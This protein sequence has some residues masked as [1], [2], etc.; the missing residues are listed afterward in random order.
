MLFRL[1]FY[2]CKL[3]LVCFP[4]ALAGL[5][6]GARYPAVHVVGTAALAIFVVTGILGAGLGAALLLGMKLRCPF[7]GCPGQAGGNKHTLQLD[8]PRCGLVE[9]NLLKDFRLRLRPDDEPEPG[10]DR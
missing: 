7:C 10:R 9:G 3:A 1:W 2:T 8:C 4:L 5:V 6:A